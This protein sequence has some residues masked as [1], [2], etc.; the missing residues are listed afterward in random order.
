MLWT[1]SNGLIQTETSATRR[2]LRL[3][4]LDE[5]FEDAVEIVLRGIAADRGDS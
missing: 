5:A 3:R 4:R 2:R 1:L